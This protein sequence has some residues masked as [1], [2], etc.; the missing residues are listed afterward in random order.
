MTERVGR[1]RTRG[2]KLDDGAV[3][4]EIGEVTIKLKEE[5]KKQ[6]FR[7][8][9]VEAAETKAMGEERIQSLPLSLAIKPQP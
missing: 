7:T 9:K 6:S 2:R 1:T 8:R 4:E 5:G 3:V